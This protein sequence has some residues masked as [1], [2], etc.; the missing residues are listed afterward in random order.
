MLEGMDLLLLPTNWP[1]GREGNADYVVRARARE[2]HLYVIAANRGG[3]ERG[4]R[5]FGRSQICGPEGDILAEAAAD[6]AD[7]IYADIDPDA[8]R[9]RNLVLKPGEFELRLLEDRRP[10]LYGIIS[11]PRPAQNRIHHGA[12]RSKT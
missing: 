7:I 10:D 8:S 12:E 2:N 11:E 4:A 6:V 9:D 3:E 1:A 5:F